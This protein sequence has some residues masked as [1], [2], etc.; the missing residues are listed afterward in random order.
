MTVSRMSPSG[1]GIPGIHSLTGPSSM[2]YAMHSTSV[3]GWRKYREP[4]RVRRSLSLHVSK[5]IK[6]S[7]QNPVVKTPL[8][9]FPTRRATPTKTLGTGRSELIRSSM[10]S[11][12]LLDG[13]EP[14]ADEIGDERLVVVGTS[15]RVADPARRPW[16]PDVSA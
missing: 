3:D 10:L 13:V 9:P 5:S 1:N 12:I 7:T 14:S 11:M 6:I 2:A 16:L 4:P 8:Q 15:A